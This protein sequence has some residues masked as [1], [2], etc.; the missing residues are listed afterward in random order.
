MKPLLP[1]LL[2]LLFSFSAYGATYT[3]T[4]TYDYGVGCAPGDCSLR[5]AVAAANASAENDTINFS[6]DLTLISLTN[7][8]IIEN[9]GSLT[10]TGRGANLL[11]IDG[12]DG[13]NRI[14][15]IN[16]AMVT[17][18]GVTLTGGN[19]G[20]VITPG[21][22]GAIFARGGSLTLDGIVLTNNT[23]DFTGAILLSGGTHRIINSTITKNSS[24]AA[25]GV[26]QNT[27][28]APLAII[29]TTISGNS[30]GNIGGALCLNGPTALRYDTITNNISEIGGG[31][32]LVLQG[33][34]VI[35]NTIVAGNRSNN[36]TAPDIAVRFGFNN[37]SGIT[38]E[39]N[40]LIGGSPGD[41]SNVGL[42]GE[43]NYQ[44]SDL[45]DIDP[46]LGEL[47]NN[48]GATPTHAL[49]PGSPAIN[50]GN[51]AGAPATDQ[52][53]SARIVGG[54]IDIGAFEFAPV[55]SRK[56]VRFF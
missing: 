43:I 47:Q 29:N 10:I 45:R 18:S 41:S 11:T 7:E 32:I 36:G 5:E 46:L 44:P 24:P 53:G 15:T 13:Q 22:G 56:R 35:G 17:V 31:G 27:A 30:S 40:N 34:F 48:G 38:S 23:A 2:T 37:N 19:G 25:C 49:L 26:L 12:G 54:T 6:H 51:N 16:G 52:R 21:G 4:K 28:D 33:P 14:F 39:G 55:K 50:A 1:L 42:G 8:I 20:S 3:V 9:N